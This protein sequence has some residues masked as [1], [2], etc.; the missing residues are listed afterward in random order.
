MTDLIQKR[1][2]LEIKQ[3]ELNI[4]RLE[5]RELELEEETEKV[6]TSIIEQRQK[7]EELRS[8]R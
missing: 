4:L 5:T 2:E 1:R 7:L 6:K 8:Q 3:F